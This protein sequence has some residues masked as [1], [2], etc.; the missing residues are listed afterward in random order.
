MFV[1]VLVQEAM[2]IFLRPKQTGRKQ[3][4]KKSE[5]KQPRRFVTI[6]KCLIQMPQCLLREKSE[7]SVGKKEITLF[8]VVMLIFWHTR[9]VYII[10]DWGPHIFKRSD[11]PFTL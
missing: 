2:H 9:G 6:Q 10:C 8:G 5:N 1:I 3:S 4:A 7:K 11:A